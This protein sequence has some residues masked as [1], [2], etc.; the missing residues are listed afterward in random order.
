MWNTDETGFIQKKHYC[1]VVVSKCSS[2]VWSKCSDANFHMT[3]IMCVYDA[4]Y[5]AQPL[6]ILPGKWLN[7]D[8]IEGCDIEGYRVT[9]A[10][11]DF[12]NSTLF[13]NWI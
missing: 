1:K 3:F 4:K 9:T 12:I 6:L 8:V 10:P 7:R 13:L 2:N 11:K 5:V